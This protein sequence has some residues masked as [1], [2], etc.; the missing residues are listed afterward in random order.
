M[1][2]IIEFSGYLFIDWTVP[3]PRDHLGGIACPVFTGTFIRAYLR[4][5]G[6]WIKMQSETHNKINLE[7]D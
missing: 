4:N 6:T 2:N 3:M 7:A 5:S 1:T